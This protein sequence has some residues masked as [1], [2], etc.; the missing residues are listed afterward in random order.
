MFVHLIVTWWS[1][2]VL[3]ANAFYVVDPANAG[4][5]QLDK[6]APTRYCRQS[7]ARQALGPRIIL[8][9]TSDPNSNTDENGNE[10]DGDDNDGVFFDDF[11]FVVGGASPAS[12]S[13]SGSYFASGQEHSLNER[14]R[15]THEQDVYRDTK[16]MKNWQQ[17]DWSVRGFSL[18][19][20]DALSDAALEN[21][22]NLSGG[23]SSNGGVTIQ[24]N[25]PTQEPIYVSKVVPDTNS[26][27]KRVWVGRSNGSVVLVRLGTE[28]T[29]HFQSKIS[30]SF[31]SPTNNDN[32]NA[33]SDGKNE[34]APSSVSMKFGSEL[35]REDSMNQQFSQGEDFL[36][37]PE[38]PFAIL[39]QFSPTTN[40]GS[41]VTHILSVPEEDYI[42]SV[43]EG[44]GQIQQWH[45][46]DDALESGAPALQSPVPLSEGIHNG[47][48]VALKTVTYQE[49]P[50]LFSVGADGSMALWDMTTADLVYNCQVCLE[51]I[52][53]MTGDSVRN[54]PAMPQRIVNCADV[55]DSHIYLGTAAGIV[56]GY[57]IKDLVESASAGGTCPL[58]NGKF[59]AHEGGVTAIAC[60]GPGSLGRLSGGG[61]GSTTTSSS[62]LFTGGQEGLVKQW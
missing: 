35:I 17:G 50:L 28:Y 33:N 4:W 21:Q 10:N 41:A 26:F 39:A 25:Q 14:I 42:F 52:S 36:R 46:S 38:D 18:D 5:K 37:P 43:C 9:S 13:S 53:E 7:P 34:D 23:E 45:I 44:T 62:V 47:P 54:D 12:S 60:G 8:Q 6:T 19:P 31:S 24:P 56:L 51:E 11:D 59:K 22:I 48:I 27:G 20:G 61:D 57:G 3:S 15:K 30:G 40:Q 29:T 55:N 2:L 16:L 49:A 58:P 1:I 32:S